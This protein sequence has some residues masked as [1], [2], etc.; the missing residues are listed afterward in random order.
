[1]AEWSTVNVVIWKHWAAGGA[2]G[3]LGLADPGQVTRGLV[4][5]SHVVVHMRSCARLSLLF[6]VAVT[7]KRASFS[8]LGGVLVNLERGSFPLA[9]WGVGPCQA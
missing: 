3:K 4:A 1:M 5:P 8:S 7:K 6:L 2:R 9:F